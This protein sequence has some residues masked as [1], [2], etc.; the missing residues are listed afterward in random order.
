MSNSDNFINEVADELRRERLFNALRRYGWIAVLIVIVVVG[1][2][3]WTEWQRSGHR[4]SSQAFGDALVAALAAPTPDA[5]REA[6]AVAPVGGSREALVELLE[7]SDPDQDKAA[8]LSALD[9][10]IADQSLPPLYRDLAILR[11]VA[12]IGADMSVSERRAALDPILAPGRPYRTL[13]LEQTAY[14]DIEAGETEAAIATLKA[15]TTDQQATPA[16][17][18]RASQMIVALGGEISAG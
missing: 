14:L 10:V 4:T 11:K 12:V 13:A 2:A 15:L 5:R 3:A 8:T 6:L 7:A 1:G 16:L 18:Q 9:G 17:R